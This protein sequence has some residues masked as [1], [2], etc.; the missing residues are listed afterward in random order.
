MRH[1][2]VLRKLGRDPIKRARLLDGLVT[3]LFEHERIQTTLAR[4]KELKRFADKVHSYHNHIVITG[5]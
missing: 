2:C 5:S 3:N 4:A 1:G